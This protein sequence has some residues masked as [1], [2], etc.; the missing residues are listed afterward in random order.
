MDSCSGLS[1]A[2]GTRTNVAV[3]LA[4]KNSIIGLT[5]HHYPLLLQDELFTTLNYLYTRT[6]P[7]VSDHFNATQ[8]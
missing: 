5:F 6:S 7:L 4:R 3:G 1:G 2:L 8:P